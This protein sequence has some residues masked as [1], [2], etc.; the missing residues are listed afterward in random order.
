LRLRPAQRLFRQE[1]VFHFAPGLR[2][3]VQ[4]K[5]ANARLD[6]LLNLPGCG[7]ARTSVPDLFARGCRVHGRNFHLTGV[8]AGIFAF[9]ADRLC[10]PGGE[11]SGPRALFEW[12]RPFI[13]AP[14]YADFKDRQSG[15]CRFRLENF[16]ERR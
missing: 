5:L 14:A 15:G 3:V 10:L 7:R 1:P 16:Y 8:I 4:K 13:I 12:T 11:D 9:V 2:A 6:L